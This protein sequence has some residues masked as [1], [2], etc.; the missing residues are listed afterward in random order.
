MGL[1]FLTP[2]RTVLLTSDDALY[3]YSV[4]SRG[5]KLV[6]VVP[7]GAQNFI[8]NVSNILAKDCAKRPV[9]MLNDM[10]EQHYRKER[11]LKSGVSSLDKQTMIKRRL[12]VAFG[13]YPVRA[14]ML[15]KEKIP[16]TKNQPAS[17]IYI[18]AAIPES[19]SLNKTISAV[20]KSLASVAA[21][22]LLPVESSDMVRTLSQKL[23]KKGSKKATWSIFI[24]QH[25]SG[26][27][28]QVVTKNGELAL[29]RMSP[30]AAEPKDPIQ[31]AQ[32][33]QKE[34]KATMSYLSRFGYD[35][36]QGLE[37]TIIANIDASD[38]LQQLIDEK[39]TL[40]ILTATQAAGL[41]GLNIGAQENQ[42]LADILHVAWAGR[43]ARFMLPMRAGSVS[44]I[45]TPRQVAAA[46]SAVLLLSVFGQAYFT[47]DY[48]SK[49]T[50]NR[51][52]IVGLRSQKNQ[53]DT[54]YQHEISK[55]EAM[56]FDV[57]L[58]QS[59]ILVYDSFENNSVNILNL[60]KAVG[61]ALGPDMRVDSIDVTK[62][63][64]ESSSSLFRPARNNNINNNDNQPKV[65][66]QARMTM[67]YPGSTNID[68]GNAEVA[69]FRERLQAQM[70]DY[71]VE[72][73]KQLKDY[74]YTEGL[75]VET[76]DLERENIQQDFVAEI[77]I[78]ALS[79]VE[80]EKS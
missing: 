45:H 4:S 41:L 42:A 61:Y 27:V 36:S 37:V 14:A 57:Q 66:F 56:G 6:D 48:F 50:E 31:W 17:D 24:G 71:K 38:A 19:D 40:N 8:D 35:P 25:R 59:S 32:E 63:I 26:N 18:F 72:I 9:L 53:L 69:E 78:E 79:K 34:F 74:E 46:A 52:Q 20:K 47:F 10:V 28:R 5:V 21:L 76:G 49:L 12:S 3:V 13:K 80:G 30:L 43:K 73:T 60:A 67:T 23:S 51:D 62:D 22:C 2:N 77:L 39:C 55:K 29:T 16:K 54:K 75:V 1:S 70:P 33:I 68:R 65:L 7:W 15:L 11:V 64:K 58:V 44:E